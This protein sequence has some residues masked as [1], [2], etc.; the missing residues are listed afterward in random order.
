[1]NEDKGPINKYK[2]LIM[3]VDDNGITTKLL[4]RYLKAN[5][6]EAVDA[7]DGVDCLDKVAKLKVE[8]KQVNLIITDVM[9][10][11]MNGEELVR[12]IKEKYGNEIPVVMVTALKD[13]KYQLRAIEVGA[14]DWLEKPIEEKLLISKAKTFTDLSNY[15]ELLTLISNTVNDGN[16]PNIYKGVAVKSLINKNF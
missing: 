15:R 16:F 10:P 3:V 7:Y 8:D 11:I 6:Y 5:G 2:G 1:M 4:C 9:M 13:T 14:D 12:R